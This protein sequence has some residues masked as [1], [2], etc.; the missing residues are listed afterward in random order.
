MWADVVNGRR[1]F[2][3]DLA[4]G[5]TMAQQLRYAKAMLK[6]YEGDAGDSDYDDSG[7]SETSYD[8]DMSASSDPDALDLD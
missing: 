5:M 3:K 8:D 2:P 1:A 4:K 6:S 7:D